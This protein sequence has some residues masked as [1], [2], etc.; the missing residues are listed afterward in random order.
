MRS[1]SVS[2]VPLAT[3]TCRRVDMCRPFSFRDAVYTFRSSALGRPHTAVRTRSCYQQASSWS[4]IRERRYPYW[5]SL[6]LPPPADRRIAITATC[7]TV[8]VVVLRGLWRCASASLL[9]VVLSAAITRPRPSTSPPSSDEAADCTF[10]HKEVRRRWR[11]DANASAHCTSLCLEQQ[12][13]ACQLTDGRD[14]PASGVV[15]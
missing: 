2:T 8:V 3:M 13:A 14:P 7:E 12:H 10:T 5:P 4:S 11:T 6:E 9:C 15:C 1:I